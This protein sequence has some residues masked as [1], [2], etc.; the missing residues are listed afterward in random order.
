MFPIHALILGAIEGFS[1]FLPISSTA[2]LI[3]TSRI[4]ELPQTDFQKS[5][6]IAI[7]LGAILSVVAL[8]G[9]RFL[10]DRATL[11]RV[12]AAF[13]PTAVVGLVLHK[14]IK[15]ILFE[16]LPTIL[17]ALLLGGVVLI[18][19][20]HFHKE[21][22]ARTA[23]IRDMTYVQ[24]A[25]VGVCQALAVVPGV[26]RS[27]ATIVGG[28]MLGVKRAAIVDFSFLLAVPTI[29]AATVLD[30]G[31]SVHAFTP[32]EYLLLGIG[33]I[34]AFIIAYFSVKGFLRYVAKHSFAAFGFYRIAIAVFFWALYVR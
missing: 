31:T 5:F 1:E 13:I 27:A 25:L 9:K 17:W 6:E 24:A 28:Q 21:E 30:L 29:L 33:F 10:T 15:N 20:E 3:L 4:L 26:S 22:K 7:Q 19:F 34:T 2:H 14:I 32:H 23:D 16:S 8:Y 12:L 18:V 11:L